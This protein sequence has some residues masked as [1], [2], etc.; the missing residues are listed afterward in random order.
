[1]LLINLQNITEVISRDLCLYERDNFVFL[2]YSSL[3]SL[4][5]SLV[6]KK[7]EREW[8]SREKKV[9]FCPWEVGAFFFFCEVQCAHSELSHTH[10]EEG[11]EKR[12][13]RR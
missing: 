8:E 12:R 13:E 5:S 11:E 7:K 10:K 2:F 6:A 1:M 3:T 9:Y 4:P